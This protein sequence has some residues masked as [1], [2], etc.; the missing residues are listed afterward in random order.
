[1][2]GRNNVKM[3]G[4]ENAVVMFEEMLIS[5][6][7]YMKKMLCATF[8]TQLKNVFHECLQENIHNTYFLMF[9]RH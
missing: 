6:F 8:K 2:L 9:Y 1:M 4:Q 5:C 3:Y 7:N